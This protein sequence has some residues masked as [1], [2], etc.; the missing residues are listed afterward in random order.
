MCLYHNNCFRHNVPYWHPEHPD[1]L[2]TLIEATDSLLSLYPS[3]LKIETDFPLI[4]IE[5]LYWAHDESYVEKIMKGSMSI[6]TDSIS[7]IGEIDPTS[8]ES[9]TQNSEVKS[10]E[11]NNK[12][13]K[14]PNTQH[15]TLSKDNKSE[16][17][18]TVL[19]AEENPT[20]TFLS[21]FS[22]DAAL[23]A[24]SSVCYAIDQ[25]MNKKAR[26]VFCIVRPPGHH[27]GRSGHTTTAPSQG[28]CLLNNV[29]IGAFYC[30]HKYNL[31]RIAVID[32]D[33]HHG[34]GTEEILGTDDP[35]SPFLFASIH[36]GKIYPYT[37]NEGV[38]RPQNVICSSLRPGYSP[39]SFHRAFNRD[40]IPRIEW[41][42][43]QICLLSSGFDGHKSE[44]VEEGLQLE[45]RDYLHLTENLLRVLNNDPSCKGKVISVLEGGYN[46]R[47]LKKCYRQHMI[48][49]IDPTI[50]R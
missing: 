4:P 37:G 19:N 45:E 33:V 9:F 16:S 46:L 32:F 7:Q 18:K 8:P 2:Q 1:R 38:K 50:K 44:P 29:A 28:Y 34:N 42:C 5:Y 17:S 39:S 47:N 3:Q 43:P 14:D 13:K 27:C 31:S 12:E 22:W 40:I 23:T 24:A 20:D 21:K 6:P 10:D 25:V 11:N 15:S 41:F 49:M 26:N 36:V 30:K 48:A 35:E